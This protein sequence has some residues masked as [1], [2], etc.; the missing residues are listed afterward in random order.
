MG[1]YHAAASQSTNLPIYQSTNLPIYQSPIYQPTS[2]TACPSSA[3]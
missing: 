2:S 1:W 3:A